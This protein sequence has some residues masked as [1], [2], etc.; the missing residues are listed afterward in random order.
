MSALK[1]TNLVVLI[2]L[3]V[4]GV[5][6][7]FTHN[8]FGVA[9]VLLVIIFRI[10]YR[11]KQLKLFEV[12][13]PNQYS[14]IIDKYGVTTDIIK[15]ECLYFDE[16]IPLYTRIRGADKLELH[17]YENNLVLNLYERCLDFADLSEIKF[18][19]NFLD[20]YFFVFK[21]NGKDMK[22]TFSRASEEQLTKVKM[23]LEN[24]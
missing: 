4:L 24:H 3:S 21:L 20:G 11:S 13:F 12:I 23:I 9:A 10:F 22:V 1:Y 5:F 7:L 17:I 16:I 14:D 2:F 15:V 8:Y 18:D 19:K 6:F